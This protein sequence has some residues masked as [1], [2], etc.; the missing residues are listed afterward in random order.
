MIDRPPSIAALYVRRLNIATDLEI[1][2]H[3]GSQSPD[4]ARDI[5]SRYFTLLPFSL[6]FT[7][8]ALLWKSS[9]ESVVQT[10]VEIVTPMQDLVEYTVDVPWPSGA[11][12]ERDIIDPGGVLSRIDVEHHDIR[13]LSVPLRVSMPSM[14]KLHLRISLAHLQPL[15]SHS[16]TSLFFPSLQEIS[17]TLGKDSVLAED[18][19][20]R[21]QLQNVLIPFFNT[22][23]PR[24]LRSLAMKSPVDLDWSEFFESLHI[25]PILHSL[26]LTFPLDALHF[27]DPSG[28]LDFTIRHAHTLTEL[29]IDDDWSSSV[30]VSL[31]DEWI[32]RVFEVEQFTKLQTLDLQCIRGSFIPFVKNLNSDALPTITHLSLTGHRLSQDWVDDFKAALFDHSIN[33]KQPHAFMRVLIKWLPT[34]AHLSLS[35]PAYG[36]DRH[37]DMETREIVESRLTAVSLSLYY[38]PGSCTYSLYSVSSTSMLTILVEG[39]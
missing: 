12:R 15:L 7:K 27:R 28:F 5:R 39:L 3:E 31:L 10:L 20:Y 25:F 2:Y 11:P 24:T 8:D 18:R 29:T 23:L 33:P 1:M 6:T 13:F 19:T 21:I 38:Y 35:F 16:R 26:N 32:Q 36:I 30:S 37:S 14:T 4:V 9:Y 17:I 34:L 22:A